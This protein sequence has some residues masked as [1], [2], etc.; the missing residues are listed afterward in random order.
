P[1][2]GKPDG[3]PTEPRW[4]QGRQP[5]P[6]PRHDRAPAPGP[7]QLPAVGHAAGRSHGE[8]ALHRAVKY[9]RA[10]MPDTS[11]DQHGADR[12]AIRELVERWAVARDALDW[13]TFR[14]VWHD[15]GR[16]MATWW[17][18]PVDDFID[19]SRRGFENGVRILHFLGGSTVDVAG[20]RAIAQT[21]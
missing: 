5:H 18:G 1:L 20:D 8:R 19:V 10:T 13:E 6:L 11:Y 4:P 14:S 21:K 7:R 16:M 17:Q 3:R 9:V 2:H 12:A 15:D